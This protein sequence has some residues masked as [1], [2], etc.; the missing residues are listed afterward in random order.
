MI[1]LLK[2]CVSFGTQCVMMIWTSVQDSGTKR[3]NRVPVKK[4]MLIFHTCT[5]E[6][7]TSYSTER[8]LLSYII[9][10]ED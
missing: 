7:E 8:S 1:N 6:Q 10:D 9:L 4:N 2:S 3:Y 5:N